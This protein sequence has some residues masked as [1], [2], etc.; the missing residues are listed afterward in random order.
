MAKKMKGK[1][2]DAVLKHGW[3][4]KVRKKVGMK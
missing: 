2:K 3:E 1:E 4:K